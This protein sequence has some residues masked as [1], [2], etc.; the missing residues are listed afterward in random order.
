MSRE[1]VQQSYE[2]N[3]QI[4][5]AVNRLTNLLEWLHPEPS[6][7]IFTVHDYRLRYR[8][9][10]LEPLATADIERYQRV[11]RAIGSHVQLGLCEY[12]IGLIYL[13]EGEF[14]GA[15]TQFDQ[16]RQQWSF[17]NESA[18]VALTHLARAVALQQADHYE[19]A[20]V[21]VARVAGWLD[22]AHLAGPMLGW[23]DFQAQV[24][25]YVAKLQAELR[26]QMEATAPKAVDASDS[27]AKTQPD[28]EAGS[29][30]NTQ[31]PYSN[32][33]QTASLNTPLLGHR[34]IDERYE[35]YSVEVRPPTDF[36]ANIQPGDWLLVDMQLEI[37]ADVQDT[38][39][40]ILIVKKEEI[41]GT[42]RVRPLEPKD[43][44]QRIYLVTLADSPTGSFWVDETTG[45]VTLSSSMATIG[46][47]RTEI[48]GVVVGFWRPMT[49]IMSVD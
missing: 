5:T 25:A 24:L 9:T 28:G 32:M 26:K 23:H 47:S 27:E 35:W 19:S 33:G 17:V 40:P 39:Q 44:F 20:M 1:M 15:V 7:D 45:T 10:G 49:N 18:A 16:A 42:I 31:R 37:K 46:V 14:R 6:P 29:P 2:N 21:S 41:D 8:L 48:L 11:N 13:Y 30:A 36:M 12:H 34:L 3:E 4:R 38:E 43:K 22:R